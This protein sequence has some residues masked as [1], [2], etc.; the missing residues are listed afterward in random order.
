MSLLL[1]G[2]QFP[3]HCVLAGTQ[4]CLPLAKMVICIM[5][6]FVLHNTSHQKPPLEVKAAIQS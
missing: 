4:L 3:L 6:Q 2:A 5:R 1:D